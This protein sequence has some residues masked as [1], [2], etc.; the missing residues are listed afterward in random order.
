MKVARQGFPFIIGGFLAAIVGG[1]LLNPLGWVLVFAGAGFA[2]FC[3]YF[4]RDPER[5]LPTDASK[6]W[7]PGDGRVL[8]VAK[9]GPGDVVTVRIFLSIFDVHIQRA[10]CAGVVDRIQYVPGAFAM[11]MKEEATRNERNIVRIAPEGREPILVEQIAG[12]VARRIECWVKE[13]QKLAA[14][15]RYGLIR[16]GSQAA[17]HLPAGA[18]ALVKPGDRAVGGVTAIGEWTK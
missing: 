13:G 17:V 16:F 6:I 1:F 5:E 12:F 3:S 7:S 8:S 2:A 18:K 11:A 15:E 9:E 4:F 14:G 10:P